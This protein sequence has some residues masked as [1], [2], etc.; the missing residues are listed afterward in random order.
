MNPPERT[1]TKAI[2]PNVQCLGL[3]QRNSGQR[4]EFAIKIA[5][6]ANAVMRAMPTAPLTG[7]SLKQL[8]GGA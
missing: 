2:P 6:I 8:K 5:A 4:P 7:Y 3:R 1:V